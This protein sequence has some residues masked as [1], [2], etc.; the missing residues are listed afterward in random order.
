MGSC[1]IL[2]L[3]LWSRDFCQSNGSQKRSRN[4]LG[5]MNGQIAEQSLEKEGKMVR[6]KMCDFRDENARLSWSTD[7]GL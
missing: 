3:S 5:D 2:F 1:G 6:V 4:P 7:G